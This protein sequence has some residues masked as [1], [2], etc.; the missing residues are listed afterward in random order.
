MPD[1]NAEAAGR[2]AAETSSPRAMRP[3]RMR[4]AFW[5]YLPQCYL[6]NS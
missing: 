3:S 1:V 4:A 2:P 5:K 6:R